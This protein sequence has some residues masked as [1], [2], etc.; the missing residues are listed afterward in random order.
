[1]TRQVQRRAAADGEWAG[2]LAQAREF[3]HSARILVT[4]NDG[5]SFNAAVT[6][7]INAGIGYA[8]AITARRRATINQR[9]HQTA[10]SLLR[11]ALGSALPKTQ[12]KF[13][14]RL[15]GR[16]DEVNYGTRSTTRDEA[17][18]LL[19]DLDDFAA[20]AEGVL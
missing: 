1:M 7:M 8:D 19:A 10:P 6:L 3:H 18:R 5:K 11:E 16:K 17:E 13:F 12:E 14:R 20:W 4:L 9:D 15:L 2:R